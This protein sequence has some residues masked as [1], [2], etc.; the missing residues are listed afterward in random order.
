MGMGGGGITRLNKGDGREWIGMNMC[1]GEWGGGG[2]ERKE[3][4]RC[5]GGIKRMN[6]GD[7]R[8]WKGMKMCAEDE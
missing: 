2:E 6:K 1:A 3:K 8:E 4:D 7:E 5:K